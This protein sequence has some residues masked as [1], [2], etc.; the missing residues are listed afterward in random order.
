MLGV[1]LPCWKGQNQQSI[2]LIFFSP[3]PSP[4]SPP[5]YILFKGVR[6][7]M[8]CYTFALSKLFHPK[9][10]LSSFPRRQGLGHKLRIHIFGGRIIFR[11]QK[12]GKRKLSGKGERT[13]KERAGPG[14]VKMNLITQ[15]HKMSSKQMYGFFFNFQPVLREEGEIMYSWVLISHCPKFSSVIYQLPH[16]SWLF[17]ALLQQLFWEVTRKGESQGNGNVHVARQNMGGNPWAIST[18]SPVV[19]RSLVHTVARGPE[20]TSQGTCTGTEL[21]LRAKGKP[22]HV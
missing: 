8:L 13:L 11:K 3:A 20:G 2:C 17:S 4:L 21:V 19:Q 9:R 22:E 5:I 6:T 15:S 14:F 18:W 1:K 16:T 7:H 12:W 10:T